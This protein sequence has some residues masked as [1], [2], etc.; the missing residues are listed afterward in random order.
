M[1]QQ[2][3]KIKSRPVARNPQWGAVLGVW[4]RIPQQPEANG[5]LG[6]KP[7]VAGGTKSVGGAPSAQKFCI[8]LQK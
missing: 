5:V 7:P 1:D 4:G 2:T 6:A 3:A 8:F